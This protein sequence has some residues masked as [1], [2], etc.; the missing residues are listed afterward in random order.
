MREPACRP[1]LQASPPFWQALQSGTHPHQADEDDALSD[2][3]VRASQGA[4]GELHSRKGGGDSGGVGSEAAAVVTAAGVTPGACPRPL[5]ASPGHPAWWWRLLVRR[6]AG[7]QVAQRPQSALGIDVRGSAR[8]PAES[9]T[10]GFEESGRHAAA[11]ASA[12]CCR[13]HP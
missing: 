7:P 12:S 11:V 9:R 6:L 13:P 5:P 3:Q 2:L 8:I 10:K 1:E 4:D